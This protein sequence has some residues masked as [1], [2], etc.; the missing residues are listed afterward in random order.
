MDIEQVKKL[1][2]LARLTVPESELEAV[3]HDIGAIL[4]FIDQIQK[5]ELS[6]SVGGVGAQV[7]VFRADIVAP[8][9][10]AHDLV[11]AAPLHQDRFVKVPKVLE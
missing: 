4:G 8:L 11:L 10:S 2:S 5:V 6:E 1:A 3:A 7:N 9:D